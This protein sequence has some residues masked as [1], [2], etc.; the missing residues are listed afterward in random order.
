MTDSNQDSSS[1][2]QSPDKE[3][4]RILER[5]NYSS[6]QSKPY[7]RE[8]RDNYSFGNLSLDNVQEESFENKHSSS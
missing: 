5:F 6:D 2:C 4:R 1:S 8:E 3:N 7:K